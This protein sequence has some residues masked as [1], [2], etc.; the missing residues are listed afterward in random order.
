MI[1]ITSRKYLGELFQAHNLTG[2]GVEVGVQQGWNAKTNILP[3]YDGFVHLVDN[4]DELWDGTRH[5]TICLSQLI[6][7]NHRIAYHVADSVEMAQGFEDGSLD[8][9]YIDAGH[10][11]KDIK[12]DYEAWEP[13][14][15]S[16]GIIA[17]HDYGDNGFGVKKYIDE[18]IAAGLKFCITTEDFHEG[19]A[20]QTW[21]RVKE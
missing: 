14:V 5:L 17:G 6:Q 2:H 1:N 7:Y 19:I 21:W 4:W 18:L 11:Y 10:S 13:K 3:F 12:A 8:W 9:V 20:Y 16:G 15:R